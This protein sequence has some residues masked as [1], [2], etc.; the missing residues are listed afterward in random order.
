MKQLQSKV[1]LLGLGL[2]SFAIGNL[3]AQDTLAL[4]FREAVDRALSKNL[5]YVI[6]TNNLEILKKEKQ[7]AVLSHLPSAEVST[8]FV[9]QTGQQFQQIEGEIVVSNL[10][11]DIVSSNLN[12]NMPVFNSGRRILDTQSAKLALEAGES[13]LARAK[14]QVVF[15]VSRRY[16]QVLLDQE[17]LRIASQNLENQKQQLIQIEGFVD[18]GLRTISDLYNQQSEVARLESVKV[19]AEIQLENDRWSLAE[20][21]QLEAGVIPVL[22]SFDPIREASSFEGL[23]LMQLYDLAQKNRQD[24]NQQDLLAT[25]F[26]KDYQAIKAMYFPRIDAF[27]NYNTFFTSLDERSLREQL[28]QIYPQNTIGMALRIPIF[29]NFESRLNTTQQNCLSK[30]SPSK[31]IT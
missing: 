29:S 5:E 15:D 24:L 19:D 21:L 11:N 6:Q 14:Q 20:Y 25:S 23:D 3:Q 4:D 1:I 22:D 7:V 26:R 10:T 31:R 18:A 27:Y 30:S 12:L 2:L 17:L 8:N 9:R 16:L 28:L 13:G